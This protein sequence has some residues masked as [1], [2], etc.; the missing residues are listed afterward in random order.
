MVWS[1]F[2]RVWLLF[3]FWW[4]WTV[5]TFLT[6]VPTFLLAKDIS[7]QIV[8]ITGGG[9]GLGRHLAVKLAARGCIIVIWDVNENG[10][11][12][13][14]SSVTHIGGKCYKYVCDITNRL[15]VYET[16]D[17]V[18]RDVGNVDI[19]INNAGIVNGKR[20]LQMHDE[21]ICNLM[22]V[23]VVSHF[24][25]LKAF[26]PHMK[27]TNSGH[28][29]SVASMAGITGACNMTDYCASKYAAVGLMDA[30][31]YELHVEKLTGI[32]A[33]TV[34][35]WYINTGMFNGVK[36]GVISFLETEHVADRI[37]DAILRNQRALLIPKQ[38]YCYVVMKSL[39][40]VLANY[41]W[42]DMMG[43]DQQ[44]DTF[45]GVKVERSE[46]QQL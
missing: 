29:V 27:S 24:W 18:R 4:C 31:G 44:M 11:S 36:P 3:K 45:D 46:E 21:S 28:I 2:R 25:T 20:L 38:M 22:N 42:M 39:V 7:N 40:P 23:N 8:L 30:L 10:L 16:A 41:I 9:G 12:Q 34:C 26:L 33:T 1:F 17:V 13:T 14:Q 15:S 6:L 5:G 43:C 19:L 37:V 32:H 35:P